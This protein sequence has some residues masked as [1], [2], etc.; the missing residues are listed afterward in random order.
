MGAGW[1]LPGPVAGTCQEIDGRLTTGVYF[2]HRMP[3]SEGV[4]SGKVE[5][6]PAA[7]RQQGGE[8]RVTVAGGQGE[9]GGETA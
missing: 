9:G 3:V 5:Q 4:V 2:L 8:V 7:G 6:E 1:F